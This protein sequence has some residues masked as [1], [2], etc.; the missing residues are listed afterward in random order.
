MHLFKRV[1]GSL[2]LKSICWKSLE[3]H[4]GAPGSP[5]R[6]LIFAYNKL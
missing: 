1:S 6:S 5:S 4:V 3:E 2:N